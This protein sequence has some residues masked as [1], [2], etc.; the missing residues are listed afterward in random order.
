[1]ARIAWRGKAALALFL[2]ASAVLLFYFVRDLNLSPSADG[3]NIPD[4][5]VEDLSFEREIDGRD[6]SVRLKRAEHH[7]GTVRGSGLDIVVNEPDAGRSTRVE[8]ESGEYETDSGNLRLAAVEGFSSLGSRSFDWLAS[9][10]AYD[11][12]LDIWTFERGIKA[13]DGSVMVSGDF[14]TLDRDSVFDIR[15]G[16]EARWNMVE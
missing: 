12:S 11:R 7:R 15:E 16:A 13:G 6:W 4:V 14:A 10:A 9:L 3:G 1:M 5:V 8:A 2:S